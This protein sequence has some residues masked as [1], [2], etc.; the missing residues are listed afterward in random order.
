MRIF[1]GDDHP[2]F[3]LGL[4]ALLNE[5]GL[6][7]VGEARSGTEALRLIGDLEPDVAVLDISM[8][9]MHGIAVTEQLKAAASSTQVIILSGHNDRTYVHQ[10]LSAGARGYVLKRSVRENLLRAIHAAC[11][12]ELYLDPGVAEY[13]VS[14]SRFGIVAGNGASQDRERSLTTRETD[15][16]R[17]IALGFTNKEVAGKL[18][19]T[20]KSVETYKRR[21]STKLNI[22]A[23]SKIVQYAM[24]QGW[25][26]RPSC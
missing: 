21:A 16:I 10:A 18:A 2:V 17:L 20:A 8:P 13:L 1:L 26:E 12:G 3:L 23:R 19:I 9:F 6:T 14:G 7:V 15:V 5:E 4:R 11:N 25:F 24:S 22:H